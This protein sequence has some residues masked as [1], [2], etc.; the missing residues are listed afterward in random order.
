MSAFLIILMVAIICLISYEKPIKVTSQNLNYHTIKATFDV[1][2]SAESEHK[3]SI[4]NLLRDGL[5]TQR[6]IELAADELMVNRG[7]F[8]RNP[9]GSERI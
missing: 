3:N 5:I 4:S 9:S 2:Q 6:E 1:I 8:T 7:M